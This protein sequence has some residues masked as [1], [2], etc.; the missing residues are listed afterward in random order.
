MTQIKAII[1]ARVTMF[2]STT[3]HTHVCANKHLFNNKEKSKQQ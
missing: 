3:A 2:P 1:N